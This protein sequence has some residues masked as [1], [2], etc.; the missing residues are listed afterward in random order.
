MTGKPK[1]SNVEKDED[2]VRWVSES[3]KKSFEVI[4]LAKMDFEIFCSAVIPSE[5]LTLD[6]SRALLRHKNF[7]GK[8]KISKIEKDEDWVGWPV[9]SLTKSFEVIFLAKTD[10]EIFCSAAIPSERLTLDTSRDFNTEA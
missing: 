8:T 6:A 2:W 7:E 1:F 3:L 4:F 10:F 5:G 9:R